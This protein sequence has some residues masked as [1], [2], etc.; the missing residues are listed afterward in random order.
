MSVTS[1]PALVSIP[2]TTLPMA[3]APM[4]PIRIG[5]APSL[6]PEHDNVNGH[7]LRL[8]SS[9]RP[10]PHGQPKMED[11]RPRRLAA[12]DRGHGFPVAR[13]QDSCAARTGGARCLRLPHVR[14]AGVP[15]A[16]RRSAAQALRLARGAGR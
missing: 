1:C 13:A 8:R 9:D 3:P 10:P 5:M 6:S 11:V 16:L 15:R 4:I 12:L 2:P 14:A 7:D